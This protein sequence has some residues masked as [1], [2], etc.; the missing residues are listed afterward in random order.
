MLGVRRAVVFFGTAPLSLFLLAS[1]KPSAF[2]LRLVKR[3]RIGSWREPRRGSQRISNSGTTLLREEILLLRGPYG[4][5][6]VGASGLSG[7]SRLRRIDWAITRR[8]MIFS[9]SEERRV[10]KEC[11]SRW[12]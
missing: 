10:G 1:A 2:S 8:A 7:A 9:R 11:R 12:S 5:G 6:S 3:N 4:A